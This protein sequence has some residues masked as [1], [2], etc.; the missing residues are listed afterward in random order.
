MITS[1]KGK[2]G[3]P[4]LMLG[5]DGTLWP[6][7]QDLCQAVESLTSTVAALS[8]SARKVSNRDSSIQ[9]AATVQRSYEGLLGRAKE[10]QRELETLLACWQR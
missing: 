6:S 7:R 10:R 1:L 4:F 9:E 2:C 5:L 3:S 8:A